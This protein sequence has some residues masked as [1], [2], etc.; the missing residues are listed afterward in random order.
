LF[1]ISTSQSKKLAFA[2]MM[3]LVRFVRLRYH[4]SHSIRFRNRGSIISNMNMNE[5]LWDIFFFVLYIFFDEVFS[6]NDIF[7]KK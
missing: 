2:L 7:C 1:P 3:Q 6:V 5:Q 4:Y